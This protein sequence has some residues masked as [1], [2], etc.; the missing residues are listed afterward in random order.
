ML[1]FVLVVL[2][3]RPHR[4]VSATELCAAGAGG[5]IV[6]VSGA[7]ADVLLTDTVE[8]VARRAGP[9]AGDVMA[10]CE[11]PLSRF[12][13]QAV[14][15]DPDPLSCSVEGAASAA[16]GEDFASCV[17]PLCE[18]LCGAT[19]I[20]ALAVE[21][22]NATARLCRRC[23]LALAEDGARWGC[24][25]CDAAAY[26]VATRAVAT[27]AAGAAAVSGVMARQAASGFVAAARELVLLSL[28]WGVGEQ[29]TLLATAVALSGSD[30]P[31]VPDVPPKPPKPSK[32]PVFTPGPVDMAPSPPTSPPPPSPPPTTSA[33]TPTTQEQQQLCSIADVQ[34]EANQVVSTLLPCFSSATPACC[35]GIVAQVGAT[36]SLPNCLCNAAVL[37]FFDTVANSAGVSMLERL[38]SCVQAGYALNFA[39][40]GSCTGCPAKVEA[41][42]VAAAPVELAGTCGNG[43]VPIER[44]CVGEC[45]LCIFQSAGGIIADEPECCCDD[46]CTQY[47]DCCEDIGPCC[48]DTGAQRQHRAVSARRGASRVARAR[49]ESPPPRPSSARRRSSPRLEDALQSMRIGGAAG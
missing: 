26:A 35:S 37:D 13:C 34:A 15:P 4:P 9:S 6:C 7:G 32:P 46:S 47:G 17:Q 5:E 36:G 10:R 1:F 20:P 2:C 40:C 48:V 28:F 3:L 19:G 31:P 8:D 21:H 38:N 24:P 18:R 33:V 25:G 39:G 27:R 14:P 44:S 43:D 12:L 30:G 29:I 49:Q 45:G 41:P 16:S 11:A 23:S 22:A 42:S